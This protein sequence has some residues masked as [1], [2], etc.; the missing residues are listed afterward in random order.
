MRI[1]S[2]YSLVFY[3]FLVLP[4]LKLIQQLLP[5][6]FKLYFPNFPKD[7]NAPVQNSSKLFKIANY[8]NSHFAG[9]TY[10]LIKDPMGAIQSMIL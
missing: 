3:I 8:S 6:Y 1:S 5:Y 4:N 10:I 2:K 7:Q 9:W